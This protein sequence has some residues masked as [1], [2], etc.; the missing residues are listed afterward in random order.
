[1][2]EAFERGCDSFVLRHHG[3]LALLPGDFPPGRFSTRYMLKDLRYALA[4][5]GEHASPLEGTATAARWLEA[6]M[7]AGDADACWPALLRRLET[8]CVAEEESP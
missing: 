1:M 3:R 5:G 8:C 6:S 4:L 2:F 7:G